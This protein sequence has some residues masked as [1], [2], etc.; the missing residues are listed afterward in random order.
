MEVSRFIEITPKL[1][2]EFAKLSGDSNPIHLDSEYA[3]T[4]VFKKPIA[5]GML[6]GSFF[7]TLIAQDYPGA[8]SVYL[9][10]E[11]NFLAPCFVGDTI[12]VRVGLITQENFKYLLSTQIYNSNND[13]IVDGKALIL[14]K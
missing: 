10:Q 3:K 4:T 2:S 13:L 5:H 8:G 14:K 1:V 6:L 9:S 12:N 11:L 7:S